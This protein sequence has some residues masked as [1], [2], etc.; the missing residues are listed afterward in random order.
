M[1]GQ[2]EG[3]TYGGDTLTTFLPS[4][5]MEALHNFLQQINRFHHTIKFTA[6]CSTERVSLL[7]MMVILKEDTICRV[8]FTKP[9]YT[10]Q[11]LSP[12]RCP[13]RQCTKSIPNSQSLRL[14]RICSRTEDFEEKFNE[15]K[16]HLLARG[17][18]ESTVAQQ[19]QRV[20]SVPRVTAL[21]PH[22]RQPERPVATSNWTA[23]FLCV[24]GSRTYSL[25][26][27]LLAPELP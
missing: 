3:H 20:A 13:S 21:Q 22:R 15:L 23:V 17:Y 14:R 27:N 8:L 5:N 7:D 6:E 4:G 26:R 25:L 16:E 9:T 10:H 11:Y 1:L 12:E 2:P 19:I 18:G 24:I